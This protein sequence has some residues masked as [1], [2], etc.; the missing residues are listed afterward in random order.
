MARHE[1]VV[2]EAVDTNGGVRPREQGEGDSVVAVF[3]RASDAVAAAV[4]IQRALAQEKWSTAEPLRVRMAVHTGEADLRDDRNYGGEAI[5]RAARMRAL[6]HGGQVLVS[7]VTADVVA[8]RLPA[9][10]E[11]ADLGVHRLKAMG[12][13]QR[14]YQLHHP[15]LTCTFPAL[16]SLDMA[17]AT[18]PVVLTS[19]VGRTD[20][21]AEGRALLSDVATRLVTLVGP[22]GCGKTRLAATLAGEQGDELDGGVWWVD[23][24]PLTDAATVA[25]AVM[26]V[27][28]IG[29]TGGRTPLDRLAQYLAGRRALLVLDNCEHVLAGT[30]DLA[31]VLLHACPELTVM[32]TSREP[33]G[34]AGETVWQVPTLDHDDAVRLF[35]DRATKARP[36]FTLD[37]TRA[38]TVDAICERLDGIPL[39]VELAAARARMLTPERILAGIDDRFHLLTGGAASDAPRQQSL[40]ASVEWSHD[41]LTEPEQAVLRRLSVFAGGFTLDAAEQVAPGGDVDAFEVLDLLGRLVDRSLVAVDDDR[42]HLLETIRAFAATRLANAGEEDEVRA[43]H[44]A[45]LVDLAET[46]G[47]AIERTS[48]LDSLARLEDEHDNV[49][50]ALTWA[51]DSGGDRNRGAALATALIPF[52]SAHG[53]YWEALLWLSKAAEVDGADG[54]ARARARWGLGHLRLLGMQVENGYGYLDAEQALTHARESGDAGVA[55]RAL[56]DLAFIETVLAGGQTTERY[57]EALGSARQAGD[58]WAEGYL[59]LANA[60]VKA[61]FTDRHEDVGPFV[62]QIRALAGRLGNSFGLVT[63]DGLE[64]MGRVRRGELEDARP[65]L[66]SQ[67]TAARQHGDPFIETYAAMGLAHLELSEGR[68]D[69]ARIL[70]GDSRVRLS[71]SA[72]GRMEGMDLMLAAVSLAE[73]NADAVVGMCDE[74]GPTVDQLGVAYLSALRLVLLGRA[75]VETGDLARAHSTIDLAAGVAELAGNPWL[76]TGALQQKAV[77]LRARDEPG[78]AEDVAHEALALAREHEFRP[79]VARA[80]EILAGLAV[81]GESWAEGVRL[82]AAAGAWRERSGCRAW[83]IDERRL[84]ADLDLARTALGDADWAGATSDGE[85]LALDDAVAYATRARGE[86]RRPSSGWAS[87]TPTETDVVRL[88]AEGLTNPDIAARLFVS[89]ATVKT[90]L[91][92]VFSKLGVATRS[93]LAAAATRRGIAVQL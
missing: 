53:H 16:R 39:A 52:W 35:V 25:D 64:A 61:L 63:A 72:R 54:R 69:A 26:A 29:D 27:L 14:V 56:T 67:L 44:L 91:V 43:R 21:L 48:D 23:L 65:G 51:L 81:V 17:K 34:L 19:F 46:A 70:L 75:L 41:L 33:L 42:Y 22:G 86:R 15:E 89:R 93:E 74:W 90:H 7:S 88:V 79:D 18:V 37:E 31:A 92:H 12:R 62:D 6:A 50:A 11:L 13:P 49:R 78:S 8:D 32:A 80:L 1:D 3:T 24:A 40:R 30:R 4:D 55:A 71:H 38:A 83:P 58:E 47:T 28:G 36:N 9:G 20:E 87:L 76:Q 59:L 66:E 68:M 85:A 2:T 10:A 57:D 5:I 84:G 77:L 82:A 45:L 73:G 60:F